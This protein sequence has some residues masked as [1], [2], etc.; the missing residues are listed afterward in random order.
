MTALRPFVARAALSLL[1]HCCLG[2]FLEPPCLLLLGCTG[3]LCNILSAPAHSVLAVISTR[4]GVHAI[5]AMGAHAARLCNLLGT[6]VTVKGE[7]N[8][9][10]SALPLLHFRSHGI[11]L[12]GR[13]GSASWAGGTCSP[14]PPLDLF[15][16]RACTAESWARPVCRLAHD[17]WA[18]TL[19]AADARA[20][21]QPS[22]GC[23]LFPADWLGWLGM[24]GA[25]S[26][27]RVRPTCSAG[28][29]KVSAG[30]I[31]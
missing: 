17:L 2:L 9:E 30:S 12:L 31:G 20:C 16:G 23:C 19:G 29:C 13:P 25:A 10:P 3:L 1:H 26:A 18:S 7:T 28:G 6:G 5:T 4:C 27:T 22:A 24:A 15:R 11:L 8:F 21:A 14:A